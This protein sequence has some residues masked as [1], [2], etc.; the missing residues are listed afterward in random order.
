MSITQ[1]LRD[2][3]LCATM[4][5]ACF[6]PVNCALAQVYHAAEMNTEQLRALDKART[7]AIIPGG[8][9][10]EHGPF[11]PSYTDGFVSR[12]VTQDVA[13]AIVERG[14]TALIFPEI[15]LGSGGVNEVAAKYPYPGTYAVRANTLRAIY[16][17]LADE[18]GEG[19]FKWIFVINSHGAP[20]HNR[21]LDQAGQYF[22]D[23]WSGQ[24]V[25][26]T[27]SGAGM[28][29]IDLAGNLS[30]QARKEDASSGHAGINETSLIL[31]LRPDLVDPAYRK[32]PAFTVQNGDMIATAK[33]DD[34]AGYFGAP[35]YSS[36][37]YGAKLHSASSARHIHQALDVLDGKAPRI[38]AARGPARP[39]DEA[40][41]ARD[42]ASEQRQQG[43]LKKNGMR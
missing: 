37:E 4:G 5:F 35:R 40:S 36:A 7:V 18:L 11:L 34:W 25:H 24:M 30:E 33:R 42:A 6:V 9:L 26:I 31:F 39:A 32:A 15:A 41:L 28:P 43:W 20:N 16:M 13:G 38:T 17:D 12:R 29:A 2:L 19:G 27:G 8:I 1:L 10:E 14:W 23:T 21:I 22:A 3:R